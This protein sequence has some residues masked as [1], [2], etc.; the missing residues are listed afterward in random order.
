M[1]KRTELGSE[2]EPSNVQEL[3]IDG[4]GCAS[5]VGKIESAISKV[6]GVTK[7]SMNF[8]ERVVT[9]EGVAKDSDL[10]TAVEDAGYNAKVMGQTSEDQR[11]E[12]KEKADWA[13]YKRL[14]REMTIALSLG[15]PLMIYSV[16]F[17]G[18]AYFWCNVFF[19]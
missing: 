18:F 8:A 17:S 10:I 5:C 4:A 1:D 14:M 11:I 13:Y 3:I 2:S 9:V 16:A 19:W 7:A 15:V 12:E 6:P